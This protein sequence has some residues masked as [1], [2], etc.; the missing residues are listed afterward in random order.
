MRDWLPK[1]RRKGC[2]RLPLDIDQE[3]TLGELCCLC[4]RHDLLPL[5]IFLEVEPERARKALIKYVQFL[6]GKHDA[7]TTEPD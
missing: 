5:L 4:N 1:Q 6:E 3:I 2:S 7:V